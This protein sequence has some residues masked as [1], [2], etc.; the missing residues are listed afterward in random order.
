MSDILAKL[1]LSYPGGFALDVSLQLPGQGVSVLLGPSGCGKTTVLR[2]LAGLERAQGSVQVNGQVWQNE[3]QFLPTHQRPIGYVFQEAS[4]FAHLTVKGNLHYGLQ[5]TAKADRRVSM[6]EAVE[7]LGIA[8]L[9]ERR[10][11]R[12][13]GGERQRVAIARALLTSPRVLLMD[14]PL[15]ALDAQRKAEVLPF[16]ERLNQ[17]SGVPLVYVTHALEEA[18]RLA[19]HL[20]LM[21][22]G[23]VVASGAASDLLPRLDLPLSQLDEASVMLPGR[24]AEHDARYGQSRI[25]VSGLP[26]WVGLHQAPV[27]QAVRVRVLARDVSVAL[28]HRADSS[29]V[30]ILP[31]HIEAL[32]D[33]GPDT[34]TLQLRLQAPDAS[35]AQQAPV[36]LARIT[37]RSRDALNLVPGQAVFAQI[38]GAAL[39]R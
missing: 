21:S 4:L 26:L 2:A 7:L 19:D 3:H 14:E 1:V 11:D 33:D 17:Q 34:V 22:A 24:V 12:L 28:S 39:M 20:V 13:S 30:N 5:R 32:R 38:K 18:V 16:L 27:G 9:L 15:S 37:R 6:D 8:H 10:P 29:I 35:G 25:E 36:L 23:R 31:A